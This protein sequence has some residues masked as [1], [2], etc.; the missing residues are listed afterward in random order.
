MKKKPLILIIS[1]CLVLTSIS[2]VTFSKI[3]RASKIAT[4]NPIFFKNLEV[5]KD[6]ELEQ[7][8]KNIVE[9]ESNKT[10][11]IAEE[12]SNANSKKNIYSKY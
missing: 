11:N 1:L 4:L 9:E 7:E 5:N 3:K 2:I 8:N 12:N 10:N 6:V